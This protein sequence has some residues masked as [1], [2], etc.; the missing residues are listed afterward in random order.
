MTSAN[1]KFRLSPELLSWPVTPGIVGA[2]SW[3]K[4]PI[5]ALTRLER[6]KKTFVFRVWKAFVIT[7]ECAH[8]KPLSKIAPAKIFA[9][10]LIK[11]ASNPIYIAKQMKDLAFYYRV[12]AVTGK[13]PS[14][15]PELPRSFKA[16]LRGHL[17]GPD[18]REQMSRIGRALPKAN[19]QIINQALINHRHIVTSAPKA[20]NSSTANALRDFSKEW[21]SANR[22]AQGVSWAP[23]ENAASLDFTASQGGRLRELVR[24]ARILLQEA[25]YHAG[26]EEDLEIGRPSEIHD[27]VVVETALQRARS[28]TDYVLKVMAVPEKGFKA[29]VLT[30]YPA[31]MLTPGDILLRQLMPAMKSEPWWD[32]DQ[33]SDKEKFDRFVSRAVD[34]DGEIVSSDLSNATDYIPHEYAQA[35]WHG[36]LDAW[37]A[38]EWIY[39]YVDRMLGP[40]KIRYPNGVEVT[41]KRGI[42]MG[43]PLS[44]PT[45]CLMHKYAVDTSGHRHSPHMIRGDDLVGI[46]GFPNSYF[47]VMKDIGFKIN[48]SK[49]IISNLG[50]VFAEKGFVVTRD[51]RDQIAHCRILQDVP[52]GGLLN[53]ETPKGGLLRAVGHWVSQLGLSQRGMRKIHNACRLSYR[54]SYKVALLKKL[55]LFTRLELGGCGWPDRSGK[56]VLPPVRSFRAI[57]GYACSHP[58][59]AF[60]R[61]V[62]RLE[63][64][65]TGFYDYYRNQSHEE[66][67]LS[68]S[69]YTFEVA[70][71][72]H[73]QAARRAYM[74]REGGRDVMTV[75]PVS[76]S[77]YYA[78]FSRCKKNAFRWIPKIETDQ[79]RLVTRLKILNGEYVPYTPPTL[80]VDLFAKWEDV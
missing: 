38:P 57:V 9:G 60:T 42:Q 1:A 45:L 18:Q 79:S 27:M 14:A 62:T 8:K 33:V 61:A 43:T 35:V 29:R 28:D 72:H 68:T 6:D 48:D 69:V 76:L 46:F 58:S 51:Q 32:F 15:E 44:F 64:I 70:T 53:L 12:W 20:V 71:S 66:T 3:F 49:T 55:P 47:E 52:I 5:A 75:P 17:S 36:I 40:Q 24:D 50:G 2:G 41:T 7:F 11:N 56:F 63:G 59:T 31:Y 65:S 10:W 19:Q 74:I 54:K 26:T 25:D 21:A 30:I 34:R 77:K 80:N 78:T 39:D 13:R 73:Y 23:R 37:G 4:L 16:W 22:P 67:T